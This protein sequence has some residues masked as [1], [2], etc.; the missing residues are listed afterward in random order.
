MDQSYSVFPLRSA[1]AREFGEL[2]RERCTRARLGP[3]NLN[4]PESVIFGRP[5]RRNKKR[6]KSFRMKGQQ[7]SNCIIFDNVLLI[8]TQIILRRFRER[9]FLSR[10]NARYYLGYLLDHFNLS[11]LKPI[12]MFNSA[13]RPNLTGYPFTYVFICR[14]LPSK[15]PTNSSRLAL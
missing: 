13:Q 14:K 8:I 3:F 4:W 10:A 11:H 2:W 15:I 7:H 5:E 1:K 6:P 12:N 9:D